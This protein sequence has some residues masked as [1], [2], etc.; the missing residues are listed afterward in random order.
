MSE[1]DEVRERKRNKTEDDRQHGARGGS[2]GPRAHFKPRP[3]STSLRQGDESGDR[4]SHPKYKVSMISAA[5]G[6]GAPENLHEICRRHHQPIPKQSEPPELGP[7]MGTRTGPHETPCHTPGLKIL[8][9]LNPRPTPTP[10]NLLQGD[11]SGDVTS[12]PTGSAAGA[13]G[14][15]EL[16]IPHRHHFGKVVGEARPPTTAGECQRRRWRRR[17]RCRAPPPRPHTKEDH[18]TNPTTTT[19]QP[20]I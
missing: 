6:P 12:H 7:E 2:C 19:S 15:G 11:Q 13:G 10:R 20:S 4:D 18:T 8:P 5:Q 17:R 16:R 1:R 9:T 3:A 14:V